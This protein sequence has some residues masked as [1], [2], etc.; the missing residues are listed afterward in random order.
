VTQLFRLRAIQKILHK[1]SAPLIDCSI[2]VDSLS[3]NLINKTL[4]GAESLGSDFLLWC[5]NS[6]TMGLT[7]SHKEP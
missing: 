7:H 3:R 1:D 5:A 4:I 6:R 2:G